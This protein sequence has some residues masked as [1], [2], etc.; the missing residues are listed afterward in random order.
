[1]PQGL[2]YAPLILTGILIVVFMVERIWF[3]LRHGDPDPDMRRRALDAPAEHARQTGPLTRAGRLMGLALLLGTF[4]VC[5]VAGIPIAFALGIAALATASYAGIPELIVF[6]RIVAGINVFS[7]L[8]IPF[9]IFAGE[10]MM[11]GGIALRL[12]RAAETLVGQV[13]GGLGVVNVLTSMLFGGIS[14]SA[15]ADTSALGSVMIPMMRE[16]GYDDDYSVN[17]TVTSSI[18]GVLIPPSHNMILYALAAGGGIS[19][20][21]LFIAGVVPGILLCLCLSVAAYRGGGPARLSHR[22]LPRL[23]RRGPGHGRGPARLPDGGRHHRRRG[24]GR[25]HRDRKR[26]H[27]RDLR[28]GRHGLL[29]PLA[30][31]GGVPRLASRRPSAPRR[32]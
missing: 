3:L 5:V 14:G 2:Q 22:H 7:L 11:R 29:L 9:F 4:A 28:A 18:A 13:R 17:V 26:G 16:R 30:D 21:S 6:Q 12:V 10:I 19:I 15:V 1:M 8:A 20:T 27:R 23:A 31:L 24:L 25:L 32:W